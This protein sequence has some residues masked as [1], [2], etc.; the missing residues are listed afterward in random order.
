MTKSFNGKAQSAFKKLGVVALMVAT[1][2]VCFTACKQTGNTGGGKPTPKTKYSVSFNVGLGHGKIKAKVDGITETETSP[3]KVEEGKT[4]TFTAKA[5]EGYQV[6]GWTLEGKAVNG[7]KTEYKLTITKPAT[8]KLFFEEIP[9]AKYTVTLTQTEHG[10]VTASP[11]IPADKQVDKETEITFT[12]K[13]NDGYRVNTWVI[14]PSEALQSGGEKGNETAK[15][16]ITADTSVSVNFEL[17]PE[18]VVLTLDPNKLNIGISAKTADGKP[19]E[20]EG[21]TET[22]FASDED[23]ELHATGTVVTLRGK[24]TKLECNDNQLVALNVKN[25]T[26]LEELLC[27]KNQLTDLDASG[28]TALKTLGCNSN[29]L[30]SLN[31]SGCTALEKLGCFRNQ[32]AS[33]NVLG[34]TA[35]EELGCHGN[36][37]TT[38]DISGLTALKRISCYTNQLNAEEMTKLLKALPAREASNDVKATLYTEKTGENEGNCKDYNTP[39]ELKAAFKEA[40]GKNWKL[41]KEKTDGTEVDILLTYAINF[42][43]EGSGGKLT[44]QADG[45]AE[46]ETSP[47]NVEEGKTVT[48]TAKADAGYKVKEWKVDGN[49]VAGNTPNTYTHTVTTAVEVKVSFEL[50][51]KAV[52]TLDPNKLNIRVVA[53]TEDGSDIAVE[54]CTETTLKSDVETTLNATGTTV[55]LKGNITELYCNGAYDNKQPLRELNVQGLTAL[56]KLGCS[57]NNLTSLNVQGLTELQKLECGAN[58]LPE[59]N[60]QGLTSLQ[61]LECK[62]NQLTELNVQGLTALENLDCQANQLTELNVQGLT[63]L[64]RLNCSINQLSS[65]NVKGLTALQDIICCI[66][67]IPELDVRGLTSLQGLWCYT[68]QLTALNVQGCASLQTLWCNNNQLTA[69]NVQGL[70]SLQMLKCEYNQLTE[71]NVQGLTS[72]QILYCW[73]NQLPELN[74][75][76]LTALKTLWC[77]KNK[78]S[79]LNVQG[80]ASLQ[81]LFCS[82]NKLTELNLQGLSALKKL[83]CYSNKLNAQAMT[84]LL[85]ALPARVAGD[86][87]N[88]FLY[89]EKTGEVEGNC[90]DYTQPAELK[91]AFDDAKKRNWKLKKINASENAEDI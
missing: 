2:S 33:L 10:K 13:A 63:S 52:L 61:M 23:A 56:Q 62:Y 60:V 39:A 35:L 73:H 86:D 14:S 43:V 81:E 87:A 22:T 88:A 3:I 5:D 83:Y 34:C 24:I 32:L 45:I 75:H 48:F 77:L 65:L 78:L 57:F 50:V 16:K 28:L 91:D 9:P 59:L 55:I 44:A 90:K 20:V 85:N 46:T 27:R 67:A 29:K 51:P 25:L 54:G 69:L 26:S 7:T 84:K 64:Q 4:I 38:L 80:C 17:I 18:E 6:K 11:E 1:L 49:V 79:E 12:A 70:T 19:I 68:N 36:Q 8:V 71:L 72:L 53:R 37:L 42:G 41:L 15:V 82:E 40:R 47:I 66:N 30:T 76:G 74:V 21:C 31:V 58:Q 89:T